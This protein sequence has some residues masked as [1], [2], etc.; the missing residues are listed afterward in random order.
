MKKVLIANDLKGLIQEKSSLLDR[1]Q[2]KVFTAATNDEA[3]SICTREGVDLIITAFDTPGMRIEDLFTIIR[4]TG[5]LRAVSTIIVCEDTL[6][7]R[8][9]CKRCRPNAIV[10]LPVDPLLLFLKMH[11]F[12]NVAPRKHYRAALAIAIEGKFKN[13]PLQFW[14]ENISASGM[15]IRADEPLTQGEGIFFSFFL[16]DGT[17]ISGYGEITRVVRQP[18]ATHAFQYGIKFTNVDPGVRS[19]IEAMVNKSKG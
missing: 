13:N 15:L 17:H 9:R 10:T 3:L 19:A 8:E 7:N 14:T 16:N 18:A 6:A 12:L 1:A 2:I 5:E 4:T 11:Q